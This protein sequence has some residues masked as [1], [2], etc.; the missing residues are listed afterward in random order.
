MTEALIED[1]LATNVFRVP[2]DW[3]SAAFPMVFAALNQDTFFPG[4][5]HD[6]LQ[7]DAKL[8]QLLEQ[9]GSVRISGEGIRVSPVRDSRAITLDVSDCLDLV[10]ALSYLLSHLPGTHRV[11]GVKNL[12]HKES[13][14]LSEVV[15][16]LRAFDRDTQLKGDEL[17][18]E[19]KV[20][21]LLHPVKLALPEDHRM[22][23]AGALFLRH[24][25]GGEVYPA[26]AVAKSY[27]G[28]FDLF[29]A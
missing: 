3:S 21:R 1:I 7:A 13:D 10:P 9:L 24:H 8:L 19:G 14:R 27:P 29:R 26:G 16:L 20:E 2:M 28:F 23:M 11:R 5:E 18:I 6:P 17:W 12:V 4:L 22:V 15:Q 25:A